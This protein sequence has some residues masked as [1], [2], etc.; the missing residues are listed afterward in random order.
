[1]PNSNEK[2]HALKR[3]FEFRKTSLETYQ[4]NSDN[5]FHLKGMNYDNSR[6]TFMV[7]NSVDLNQSNTSMNPMINEQ[8]SFMDKSSFNLGNS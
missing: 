6:G 3:N 2:K 5:S 7:R 8:H 4:D 1:M